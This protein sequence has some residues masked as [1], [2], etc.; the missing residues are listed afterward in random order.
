MNIQ[1]FNCSSICVLESRVTQEGLV[2]PCETIRYI[3]III[4]YLTTQNVVN[5]TI[6]E[7]DRSI[8]L[9]IASFDHFYTTGP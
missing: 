9:T 5:S 7:S 2:C 3:Y 8:T 1:Y 6:F 4:I